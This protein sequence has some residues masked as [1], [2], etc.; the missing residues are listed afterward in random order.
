MLRFE[1]TKYE[2]TN[3]RPLAGQ[4]PP[5]I[6]SVL[7]RLKQASVVRSGALI[8]RRRTTAVGGKE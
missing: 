2:S 3:Q 5:H 4:E 6:P 1:P 7:F 8:F